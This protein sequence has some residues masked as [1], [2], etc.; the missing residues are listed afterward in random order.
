MPSLYALDESQAIKA[1][2]GPEKKED[3][4]KNIFAKYSEGGVDRF[5]W[6]WSWWAL[7]GGIFYLLYRKLYL[8]VALYLIVLCISNYTPWIAFI[9]WISSG[10]ILPYFVYKRYKRIKAQTI[11]TP[12]SIQS[13]I[14]TLSSLGG[15]NRWALW[16]AVALYMISLA[17]ALLVLSA[18]HR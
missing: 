8:E 12:Q 11:N 18:M 10:G 16:L 5:R 14:H 9:L 4:Y 2:I 7:F 17:G 1:Y 3:F 13:Q 15:V 6:H